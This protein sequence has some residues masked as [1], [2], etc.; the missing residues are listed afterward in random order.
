MLDIITSEKKYAEYIAGNLFYC[1]F[2]NDPV[3]DYAAFTVH[4]SWFIIGEILWH[5]V[6]IV[7]QVK[8]EF[9]WKI[10]FSISFVF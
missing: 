7:L 1:L 3:L 10:W 6:A 8:F 9:S 2:Y 4:V 5:T